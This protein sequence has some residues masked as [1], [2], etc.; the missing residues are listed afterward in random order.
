MLARIAVLAVAV[1]S[2]A[3]LADQLAASGA[4]DRLAGLV[5]RA[6]HPGP[7]DYARAD[8]LAVRARARSFD[9]RSLLFLANLHLK[10]GD[11]AGAQRMSEQAVRAEPRNG[12]AWLLLATAARDR[13]PATERRALQRV[14]ELAPPVPAP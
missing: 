8:A 1:V 9:Q 11:A 2:V 5:V 14:R 7:A 12:E 6:R 13:D 10:G 3:W 4:Q